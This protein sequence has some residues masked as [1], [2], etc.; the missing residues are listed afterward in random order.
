MAHT[1]EDTQMTP[2]R[3]YLLRGI[4]DWLVDNGLTPHIVVNALLGGVRVP[5]QFVQNGQIVL[6]ISPHSVGQLQMDTTAVSFHA[7]FGGAPHQIYVPMA[8]ILAIHA[9]ENGAGTLFEHE[10]AY[11]EHDGDIH[12]LSSVADDCSIDLMGVDG[13]DD[14]V[15]E[16]TPPRGRP[17]LRVVK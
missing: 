12:D 10:V 9:H 7:R 11:D 16:P 13:D 5:S 2:S 1:P 8:A 3:P 4:Y 6:N 14:D 17:S 15:P